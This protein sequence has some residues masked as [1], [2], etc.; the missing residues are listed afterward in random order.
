MRCCALV[1]RLLAQLLTDAQHQLTDID[2]MLLWQSAEAATNLHL[3]SWQR[4]TLVLTLRTTDCAL[5]ALQQ[6]PMYFYK[7]GKGRYK[8]APEDA[9]KAALA[10]IERKA[11]EAEQM[12]AWVVALAAGMRRRNCRPVV[13]VAACAR[14]A[15]TRLQGAGGRRPIVPACR[16][17]IC[18]RAKAI[19]STHALHYDRF[20]CGRHFEGYCPSG[21]PGRPEQPDLPVADVVAFSID[22]D[23]TTEIDDAF[24][25]TSWL[26]ATALGIHIAAPAAAIHRQCTG[27]RRP[28]PVVHGVHAGQQDHHV[29]G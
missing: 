3:V 11:R 1:L 12:E 7:R 14:Q 24:R 25:W 21:R 18:S 19:P 8:R 17:Y 15:V 16:R 4:N 28:R 5:L 26:G 27:P 23:S 22:D 9:L 20:F 2:M 29:A 10:S 13:A 6:A